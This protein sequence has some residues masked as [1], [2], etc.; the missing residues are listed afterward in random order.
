MA[1]F[2]ILALDLGK[3]TGWALG[4][5]GE[6]PVYGSMDFGADGASHA[7]VGSKF[8]AWLVD[9]IAGHRPALLVKEA[10]LPPQAHTNMTSAQVLFGLDWSVEHVAYDAGLYAVYEAYVQEI[11][12]FFLGNGGL[13]PAAAEAATRRKCLSCGWKPPDHNAA[14]ALALWAYQCAIVSPSDAWKSLKVGA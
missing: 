4:A 12:K 11:R 5:P 2:T 13:S 7:A 6:T 9:M 10:P 3:R 14:D 8:C 1:A